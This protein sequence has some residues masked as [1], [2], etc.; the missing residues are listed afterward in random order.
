MN[1]VNS[2]VIQMTQQRLLQRMEALPGV[3]VAFSGGVD[4][5]VV[6]M[7]AQ[8]ALGRRAVA[9][10]AVS[11][12]LP[13]GELESAQACAEQIGIQHHL[14]ETHE[15][16]DDRYVANGGDRC[17]WCKSALYRCIQ[18]RLE[19]LGLQYIANGTNTDDTGDVRPGLQAAAEFHV[20]SPLV[21]CG[22]DKA[23]VRALARAWGLAVWDKPAG[24]C[25]ASRIAPKVSVTRRRLQMVDQAESFLRERGFSNV[26]VRVHAN[27]L[28][29]IEVDA[30]QLAEISSPRH[31]QDITDRFRRLGFRFVTVDLQGFRSGSLNQLVSL[32]L[33]KV[34]VTG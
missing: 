11:P 30:G 13:S 23:T 4:S 29:R 1:T 20:I 27:E 10:T 18:T 12:S 14:I 34:S 32:N 25:L 17:Y 16:N 8:I 3:A 33:E 5:A 9:V 6:A 2:S 19:S 22:M 28:A 24:P 31:C 7:A 15:M 21:D 26:R